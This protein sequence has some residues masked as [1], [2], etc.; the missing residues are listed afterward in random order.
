MEEFE[1]TPQPVRTFLDLVLAGDT[2]AAARVFARKA[3]ADCREVDPAAG[4]FLVPSECRLEPAKK[5]LASRPGEWASKQ[6]FLGAGGL[7]DQ[8][9]PAGDGPTDDHG[10]VH[11]GASLAAGQRFKVGAQGAHDQPKSSEAI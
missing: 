7:A 3:A 11:A 5:R 6:R 8:E 2:I 9:D 4:R 10:L 1:L